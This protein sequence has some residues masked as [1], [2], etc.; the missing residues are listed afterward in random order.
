[1]QGNW[2]EA[3]IFVWLEKPFGP[4]PPLCQGFEITLGHT[5][6]GRSP[7]D[8]RSARRKLTTHDTYKRQTTISPAG[9]ESAVPVS[10]RPQTQAFDLL[11]STGSIATGKRKKKKYKLKQPLGRRLVYK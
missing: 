8:E 11:K 10:E 2:V 6:I 3:Y 7:S 1:M 4:S 9:F 5:T